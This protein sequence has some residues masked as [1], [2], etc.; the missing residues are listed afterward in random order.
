M[1]KEKSL[2]KKS[3]ILLVL[4]TMICAFTACGTSV[5]K[6]GPQGIQGEQGEQGIP[7]KDGKS[8][9]EIAVANGYEG[10]EEQWLASLV[11]A[12][13]DKGE[14]GEKGDK[15]DSGD[16]AG[17]VGADGITPQLRINDLTNMWEVSY[18]NGE[19]WSSLDVTA[20]GL[21]GAQGDKGEKGEKGDKGDDGRGIA[22]IA[23]N[24]SGE[25]VI[26]YTDGTTVNLGT[27]SSSGN[28]DDKVNGLSFEL[29]SD[30]TYKVKGLNG[31]TNENVVIPTTYCGKFVTKIASEAFI[32]NA[33]IK[34]VII[35]DSVVQIG[36][37][38]FENCVN[39]ANV[40]VGADSELQ[41]IGSRAFYSC[42]ALTAIYIPYPVSF[43]GS[44]AFYGSGLQSATFAATYGWNLYGRTSDGYQAHLSPT[45]TSNAASA[46]SK[47]YTSFSASKF[48]AKNW[49]RNP[50]YQLTYGSEQTL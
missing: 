19:T 11:G 33:N 13:G 32:G 24:D 27:I 23:F 29:L 31:S 26:T 37:S 38:A 7:G 5:G 40:G 20:T 47:D 49:E 3:L 35:P 21:Q 25:L 10:T 30:G 1:G 9:Y 42:S 18:D 14:K 4:F 12:K 44:Y 22:S 48:Y 41:K 45:N 50:S 43:I 34:S 8:A 16:S 6:Q 28:V 39:L 36:D 17:T 2:F 15:G 46:L